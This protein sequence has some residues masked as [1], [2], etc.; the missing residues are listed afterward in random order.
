MLAVIPVYQFCPFIIMA[1]FCGTI[2]NQLLRRLLLFHLSKNLLALILNI[3]SCIG[4]VRVHVSFWCCICSCI[5]YSSFH[6]APLKI[7]IWLL[8]GPPV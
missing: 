5:L 6:R 2:C 3:I 1:L 8:S 4:F 7:S